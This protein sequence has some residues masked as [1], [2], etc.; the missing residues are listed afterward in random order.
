MTQKNAEYQ[1]AKTEKCEVHRGFWKH[2][3]LYC[4]FNEVD[5][6]REKLTSRRNTSQMN[7]EK[8]MR[9]KILRKRNWLNGTY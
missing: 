6:M 2:I 8:N 7:V 4:H 5:I 9:K 3:D 1:I